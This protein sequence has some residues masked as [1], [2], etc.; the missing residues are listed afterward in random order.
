[1]SDCDRESEYDHA[2][3]VAYERDFEVPHKN[4]RTQRLL[5]CLPEMIDTIKYRA[6]IIWPAVAC[7]LTVEIPLIDIEHLMTSPLVS[8][9]NFIAG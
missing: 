9:T 3:D 8:A 6:M 2:D 7:V 4:A 5:W 1:M